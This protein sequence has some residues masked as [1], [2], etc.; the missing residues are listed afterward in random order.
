MEKIWLNHYDK[1]VPADIDVDQ[2]SSLADYLTQSLEKNA[3]LAAFENMSVALTYADIDKQ[4]KHF[5]S[6]LQN[7][8]K[9]KK[10]DRFA[11]MLPNL[12]QYVIAMFAA[13]RSG[14]VVVNV[15]PL[16]TARELAHQLSDSGAK[17][18]L[19]L[20]NFADVAEK[21]LKTASVENVIVTQVGDAYPT[22]RRKLVN[23]AVRYIK[24][25]VPKWNIPNAIP[26]NEALS[27]GKKTSFV[28]P[29][30]SADDIAYLQY[31]GGTTGV[32]KGAI[33]TQRNMV[34]N[35]VQVY[36]WVEPFLEQGVPEIVLTSLPLYHIFSLTVNC[37]VFLHHGAKN[38]LITNPRDIPQFV[39]EMAKSKFTATTGV[40]TL[41]NALLN[42]KEF[43]NVDFSHAKFVISGGMSLQRAVAEKWKQVTGMNLIE[44]YGLTEA[45]PVVSTPPISTENYTGTIG[46]P[47]PSTECAVMDDDGEVLQ[48][49]EGELCVRGP[50]VMQGYWNRP[51]ATDK[52]ITKG[53]WLHTGD[54]AVMD[55]N[56]YFRIV[57][58]KKNMIVV[59]GFNVYPNEI[60]EIVATMP[61]VLEV[62]AIGVPDVRTGER[63]KLFV[64]KKDDV[65][66]KEII[67]FCYKNLT[68]YKVPKDIEFRDEL[69][70]SNVGK[71]LHRALK[72]EVMKEHVE[73]TA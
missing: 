48:G 23:F 66:Q 11:I 16:Y 21:A 46:I 38:V 29:E 24:R 32:A 56:G 39:K 34:A 31:T 64:V 47:L 54:V 45:S 4:S 60:E 26:F 55:E 9:L 20:E 14:I 10:G 67:S 73:Q 33:L 44:G 18:L 53:G 58:R 6:F 70:K 41:F 51:E 7:E 65:T 61:Q 37:W 1:G 43:A 71:I 22:I 49:H 3:S 57:D 40:N 28:A 52:A 8:L 50:Q 12:L 72:D 69:P 2:Y 5:A 25:M 15:N 30:I 68:R 17:A 27:L 19:V 42:N 63:I 62:A 36:A 59:S 13:V 35:I